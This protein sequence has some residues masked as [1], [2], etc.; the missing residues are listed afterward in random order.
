MDTRNL[1]S[2]QLVTGFGL[3]TQKLT[4]G[5][6]LALPAYNMSLSRKGS[7]PLDIMKYK[8]CISLGLQFSWLLAY[9]FTSASSTRL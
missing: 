6:P 4:A 8:V 1:F 9:T 3:P 7:H 2:S 5:H